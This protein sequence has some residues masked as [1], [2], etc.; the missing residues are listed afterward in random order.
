MKLRYATRF[1]QN[2]AKPTYLMDILTWHR[3]GFDR[4]Q[5]LPVLQVSQSQLFTAIR[6]PVVSIYVRSRGLHF[7]FKDTEES[8]VH[9]PPRAPVPPTVNYGV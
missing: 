7:A 8:A 4:R 2:S 6:I 5:L 9:I 1:D 3:R